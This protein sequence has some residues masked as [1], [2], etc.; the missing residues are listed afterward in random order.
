MRPAV[1]RFVFF[2]ILYAIWIG[3][4]AYLVVGLPTS[5]NGLS[6]I[7]SRP[8]IL[9]SDLDVVGTIDDPVLPV[10]PLDC[11]YGQSPA[12]DRA[13]AASAANL[14]LAP[15]DS[16]FSMAIALSWD[17]V[18]A[19]KVHALEVLF[20]AKN[21]PVQ[22][23]QVI[24]VTNFA[25]CRTP[26]KKPGQRPTPLPSQLGGLGSCLLPL[27][28]KTNGRTWEVVPLPP[29]PGFVTTEFNPRAPNP[30][31][32]PRIYTADAETR[33]QYKEVDKATEPDRR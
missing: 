16:P 13:Q 3:Y 29:S 26:G 20:P 8:Q 30:F 15:L 4:L 19:H 11:Y 1:S 31:Q 7:L 32:A 12:G 23:G 24:F 27:R 6:P 25:D 17:S 22:P 18:D 33:Q 5:P 21:P 9:V 10:S 14:V 2:A 28:T